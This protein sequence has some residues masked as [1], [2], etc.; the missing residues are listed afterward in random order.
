M[1]ARNTVR[2]RQNTSQLE[3]TYSR[4]VNKNSY[5]NTCKSAQKYRKVHKNTHTVH[6]VQRS[7][8]TCT[9]NSKITKSTRKYPSK[10][11]KS[12]QKHKKMAKTKKVNKLIYTKQ[13][14]THWNIAEH[15]LIW[16]WPTAL[17][18]SHVGLVASPGN[19]RCW[20]WAR[21]SFTKVLHYM[22]LKHC[23]NCV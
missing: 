6:T 1:S 5:T 19:L 4:K 10:I 21:R 17:S 13:K 18:L 3:N 16:K 15:V 14:K 11:Y 9:Q 7:T 20:C 2:T 12:H 22:R 8:R 23:H